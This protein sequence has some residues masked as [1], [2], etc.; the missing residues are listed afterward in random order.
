QQGNAGR[1]SGNTPAIRSRYRCHAGT[2][3]NA[4][5]IDPALLRDFPDAGEAAAVGGQLTIAEKNE[6]KMRENSL[7]RHP[8]RHPLATNFQ[9]RPC[10][11]G[12]HNSI[13]GMRLSVEW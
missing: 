7:R 5:E 11:A 9:E 3:R 4:I 1:F 8:P 12:F 13:G 6:R 10:K 2:A